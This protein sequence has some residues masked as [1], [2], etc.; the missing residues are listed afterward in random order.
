[1]PIKIETQA[2]PIPGY[3]LIERLGGGGFGEVWKAEAPGGLHKAIKFVYGDLEGADEEG[4]RAG[5][6]LKALA[7]VKTVHHPYILSLERFDIID[8]QLIIVMEL[9][10]RTLWD[11]FRECRGQ[12]LVGIPRQ[13]LLSYLAETAEALDLMNNQYQL[14]HLDIKP[15]NLFL[16]HNHIK[17]ADFGLVKDLEGSVASVTG[18]VTPVYA[19]PETFE[20][21]VSCF[22][23]QYSLAIVYQELLTGQR[24]FQGTTVRQLV[25]QHLRE[26]PNLSSL[27]PSDRPVVA[28]ALDKIPERRFPSCSEFIAALLAIREGEGTEIG[29]A[30]PAPPSSLPPLPVAVDPVALEPSSDLRTQRPPGPR[31]KDQRFETQ[32][33][34]SAIPAARTDSPKPTS[35]ADATGQAPAAVAPPVGRTVNSPLL[36]PPP[37]LPAQGEVV[38][39]SQSGASPTSSTTVHPLHRRTPPQVRSDGVLLPALVVGL[40]AQGQRVLRQFR[41][42]IN[43]RFG[44]ADAL[45][46]VRFLYLDTDPE[47]MQEAI[48]RGEYPLRPQELLLARLHRAAHYIRPRETQ[49]P[50]DTWLPQGMIYRISRQ[51]IPNGVRCLGRLAF[52]DNYPTILRRLRAEVEAC[53]DGEPLNQASRQTSL[54]V[55]AVTPRVYLVTSLGGG[56]GSGMFLD[57][58]YNLR[59]LLR[60][61]GHAA[62]EIVGI[63]LLPPEGKYPGQVPA[64]ANAVAALTELQHFASPGVRF[65]ARYPASD[66]SSGTTVFTETGSPFQRCLLIP[67]EEEMGWKPSLAE[68]EEGPPSPAVLHAAASLYFELCTPLGRSVEH[69]R[70]QWASV[71]SSRPG[72]ATGQLLFQSSGLYR[73]VWPRQQLL[74]RV[75]RLLCRRLVQR[76]MNKDASALKA[77]IKE[78]VA[79]QWQALRLASEDLIVRLQEMC[80]RSLRQAPETL[81][82]ALVDPLV[83]S[84]PPG[85]PQETSPGRSRTARPVSPPV[86]AEPLRLEAVLEVLEQLEL[87]L[88]VPEGCR[89]PATG[90]EAANASPGL[91][92]ET[93]RE[94]MTKLANE[95]EL[96]MAELI[97]RLIEQPDFRLAGA[98][99][100]I[101]QMSATVEQALA[102]LETLAEELQERAKAAYHRII[103]LLEAPVAPAGKEPS[104]WK[105]GFGKK[106]ASDG[107]PQNSRGDEMVELLRAYPKYRYQGL[108]LHHINTFYVGLRGQLSDQLREVDYCRQRLSGLAE[109]FNDE[110]PAPSVGRSLAR[111]VQLPSPAGEMLFPGGCRTF[112]EAVGRLE[113]TLTPADVHQFDQR[114]QELIRSQFQALVHV[115]MASANMVR[116]LQPALQ[117]LGERFVLERLGSPDVVQM[118]LH[119]HSASEEPSAVISEISPSTREAL[120]EAFEEAGSTLGRP[121][122]DNEAILLAAP[123]GAGEEKLRQAFRAA[124]PEAKVTAVSAVEEVVLYRE[125]WHTS[126]K[127]LRYP[128]KPAL[129]AYQR[130]ANQEHYSPHARIDLP[131]CRTTSAP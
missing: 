57:L 110:N 113:K 39:T 55:A 51:Q 41:Q 52:V 106:V 83:P 131:W 5:Q 11:R 29:S 38:S 88:G 22:S 65:Q 14:Q 91:L 3:R 73:I 82:A 61:K 62:A 127:E 12:G 130:L 122:E 25:M 48:Q 112:D 34:S 35:G 78:W 86:C 4:A 63:F 104:G 21:Y 84:P 19:A 45:P 49:N 119:Q 36:T 7:R 60:E 111:S 6:E 118:Y 126:L 2:E 18:G 100:T 46:H 42:Q 93:L 28:R 70:R 77:G 109:M 15:Q 129:E 47:T 66:G 27:P 80:E 99:E 96:R 76:W 37:V 43:E 72:E 13:E 114:A 68:A 101:R 108:I 56:T 90:K 1:M 128:S 79:Q 9:A 30:A 44:S 24:P 69:Q 58:A 105:L 97:V 121:G 50:L 92:V 33:G 8:G 67:S 53:T 89:S 75:G 107:P 94:G 125:R 23:D 124:V 31:V 87:L 115:C 117:A 20:G 16:V 26:H 59:V 17:V 120:A 54:G 85:P 123:A 95:C 32:E 103:A 116:T 81:F 74:A 71:Q 98:E 102:R 64:M 40:G 10:D